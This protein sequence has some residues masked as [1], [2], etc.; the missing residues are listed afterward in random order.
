[1]FMAANKRNAEQEKTNAEFHKG[2]GVAHEL[3][4]WPVLQGIK[5]MWGLHT[6]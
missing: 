2:F 1:M 5:E 4:H 6:R 3:R